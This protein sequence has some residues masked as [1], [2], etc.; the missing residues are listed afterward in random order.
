MF[1]AGILKMNL[2]HIITVSRT[3]SRGFQQPKMETSWTLKKKKK[4]I[5]STE[6]HKMYP[7]NIQCIHN[8]ATK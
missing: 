6:I 1:E 5:E 3:H 7:L 2:E 4:K 8:D